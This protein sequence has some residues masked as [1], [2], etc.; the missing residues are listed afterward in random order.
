MRPVLSHVA[1]RAFYRHGAGELPPGIERTAAETGARNAL[2]GRLR[3]SRG[4][5]LPAEE[6]LELLRE[7][8]RINLTRCAT[9]FSHWLH[10]EPE[11]PLLADRLA[12]AR[13]DARLAPALEARVLERLAALYGAD[14]TAEMSPAYELAEDLRRVFV[15]YYHHAAPFRAEALHAVWRRCAGRDP[16]CADRLDRVLGEGVAPPLLSRR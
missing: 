10:Q 3:A 9:L 16:R 12:R 15:R 6:R 2:V 1:A 11:S 14:P 13:E 8:C 4:G 5:V 7:T